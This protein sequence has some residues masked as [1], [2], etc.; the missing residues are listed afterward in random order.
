METKMT[1][2][3]HIE[4]QIEELSDAKYMLDAECKAVSCSQYA[5]TMRQML[6]VVRAA[7]N[8][9]EQT[10]FTNYDD[11]VALRE[12]LAKLEASDE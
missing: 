5:E 12:A 9:Y 3:S 2:F 11:A 7:K 6:E 10:P 8:Y 1:D 4:K